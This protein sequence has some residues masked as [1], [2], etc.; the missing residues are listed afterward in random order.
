MGRV[1]GFT[2]HIF[3]T[4]S[5]PGFSLAANLGLVLFLFLVGLEVDLRFL[6][7]NWRIALSVGAA[8]MALPFGMGV[9]IA[10]GLYHQF[11]EDTG[12]QP[13][14]FGIYA[15]FI[16]VALAITAF[17][18][19]CR[20]LTSLK[21]LSTP[22][23][24]I[25]LSAGV[26][27]DVVGW[28]LLALCVALV[29]SGAGL[30]ALWILL[31]A[32]GYSLFL[33]YAIRP[34]FVWILRRTK[35]LENGPTQG[36]VAL[37]VLLVL[38]SSFF[39]NIIGIHAIF[40]A[41][42]IGLICPHEGGFAI[43]LTEKIEDLV[44]TLFLPLYFALSG[45]NTD[46][47]L[48][49]NGITWG[50]VVGVT[51]IAFVGKIAGGTLAS[52]LNGLVWRESL[53]IGCLMSCKGL[54]ELIVLNI[55][56]QAKI[57]STRTF[58]IFV[59]MA[60][61]TTFATTPLVVWLYPPWYQEKLELWKKGKINWDGTPI[62]PLEDRDG[63]EDPEK[64]AASRI[65]V[66]LR[67]D[68]LSSLFSI[69]SL[70]TGSRG[71]ARHSL[72]SHRGSPD[73]KRLSA[74]EDA[75]LEY[76]RPLRIYGLRLM[77]LTERNSSVMKVSELEEYA[78]R[79]PII[80]AFGSSAYGTAR[81]VTMSG[82]IAV[83]PDHSYADT[84]VQRATNS[85]SHLILL[86]WSETGSISEIPPTFDHAPLGANVDPLANRDFSSLVS[87]V[88]EGAHSICAV[89]VFIDKSLLKTGA[90]V[91]DSAQS[92][93]PVMERPTRQLNRTW[94]GVSLTDLHESGVTLFK[95]TDSHGR[96]Q[97]RV[98]YTGEAD[99]LFAVKLALQLANNGGVEVRI[100]SVNVAGVAGA[101]S[102]KPVSTQQRDIHPVL[103][104]LRSSLPD[105]V[106]AHTSFEELSAPSY[107][108][109]SVLDSLLLNQPTESGDVTVLVGRGFVSSTVSGNP[110]AASTSAAAQYA[111]LG[112]PTGAL[113]ARMKET[114]VTASL[115]VV[116]GRMS[117]KVQEERNGKGG[118]SEDSISRP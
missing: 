88:F 90:S 91:S 106:K 20:I 112:A 44:S 8:G 99:S 73:K 62:S 51:A 84:L 1:P 94:T 16:G 92:H 42:M 11:R 83:V 78:N 36:V 24:V 18:V 117:P 15:L 64:D 56:L 26:G 97:I 49:D 59:V 77:E 81:D 14:S 113:L 33:A 12:I 29:N 58:T 40:G 80:K 27:N 53:T 17:P 2:D 68:G 43:K 114:K 87:N 10:Y 118:F 63:A 65:L 6:V 3:P 34:A 48:L 74:V 4:A 67:T 116:Q 96:R 101:S 35:S 111:T 79:D 60:L 37:T 109:E 52:R 108:D 13:I 86:P 50:Y 7:S 25:V 39:T 19:L 71:S 105:T 30:T 57:L 41:F 72:D 32:V 21:L 23:G 82:Q 76:Q 110:A 54:V 95:S 98:M 45:L 115:L 107:L 9:G 38:A 89:G 55:G 69:V 31:C 61:V 28:I 46:L 75:P 47:G 93:S 66:Y 22:V 104:R 70:L 102:N 103:K 85:R 5:M 100:V